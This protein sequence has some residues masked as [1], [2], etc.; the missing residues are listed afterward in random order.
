MAIMIKT[1][2]ILMIASFIAGGIISNYAIDNVKGFIGGGI[3][4]DNPL[5][6]KVSTPIEEIPKDYETP[7]IDISKAEQ[8]TIIFPSIKY[9]EVSVHVPLIKK[10]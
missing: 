6:I 10:C 7:P 5:E 4:S 2:G 8:V 9:G 1:I 3:K